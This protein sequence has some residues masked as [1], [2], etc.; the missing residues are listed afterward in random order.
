MTILELDVGNTRIKWRNLDTQM[1]G[2]Q[3]FAG[4]IMARS[5]ANAVAEIADQL[6][7]LAGSGM[8]RIRVSSVQGEA[9]AREFSKLAREHWGL[10][11]EFASVQREAA[12]VTNAYPE[13][14]TMGIDRWLAVLAAYNDVHSACCVLDCGSAIT[15][16]LVNSEGL[17]QGGYIVPGLELMRSSLAQKTP[18]LDI[19]PKAWDAPVPGNSTGNAISNGL[20]AMVCSLAEHCHLKGLDNPAGKASW[21]LTG[22]DAEVISRHLSFEHDLVKDLVLDGLAVVLP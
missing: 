9:F 5:A 14:R 19:P 18:A 11:A 2:K 20:V 22:G 16:D 1:P 3:V 21:Y 15:L 8:T 13:Y 7:S 10:E 4:T 6:G 12:G 17:H